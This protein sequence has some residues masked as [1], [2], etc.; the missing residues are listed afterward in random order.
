MIRPSLVLN[1]AFAIAVTGSLPAQSTSPVSPGTF[2]PRSIPLGVDSADVIQR[3]A[4]GSEARLF[5]ATWTIERAVEEGRPV[6]I[7]SLARGGYLTVVD[8]ATYAPVRSVYRAASPD[9]L[10]SAFAFVVNGPVATGTITWA[11][12]PK[13]A[14]ADTFAIAP[15]IGVAVDHMI[16]ALP[17]G[18][19]FSATIP[20]YSPWTPGSVNHTVRVLGSERVPFRGREVDAWKVELAPIGGPAAATRTYWVDKETGRRLKRQNT[21]LDGSRITEVTR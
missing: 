5:T 8:A 10:A 3:K 20:M 6:L 15:F 9:T 13:R 2:V 12:Q 7:L 1:A 11:R 16:G 21:A 19:N 4:D 14:I 18:D 17:L